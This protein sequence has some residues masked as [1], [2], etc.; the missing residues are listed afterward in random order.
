MDLLAKDGVGTFAASIRDGHEASEGVARN[1]GLR[2]TDEIVAG[3][4]VWRTQER[5]PG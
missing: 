1:L 5:S 3:E 2:V 4:R